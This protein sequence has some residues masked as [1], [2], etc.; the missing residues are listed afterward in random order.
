MTHPLPRHQPPR[1][2][3]RSQRRSPPPRHLPPPLPPHHLPPPRHPRLVSRQSV[4]RAVACL[5]LPPI[6]ATPRHPQTTRTR[7]HR[8]L[9]CRQPLWQQHWRL[10]RR[11]RRRSTHQRRRPHQT[12]QVARRTSP[13]AT[14]L[15]HPRIALAPPRRHHPHPPRLLSWRTPP[16]HRRVRRPRRHVLHPRV[17]RHHASRPRRPILR[18]S[19]SRASTTVLPTRPRRRAA[20]SV[21]RSRCVLTRRWPISHIASRPSCI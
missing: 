8:R 10:V 20:V 13:P 17:A 11:L 19:A 7:S 9:P 18:S 1:P 12:A 3:K 14:A 4:M 16:P 2:P 6:S 5:S 15:V 21:Y